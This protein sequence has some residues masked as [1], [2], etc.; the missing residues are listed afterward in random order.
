MPLPHLAANGLEAGDVGLG[1]EFAAHVAAGHEGK[2]LLQLLA[3]LQ[4]LALQAHRVHPRHLLLPVV[5]LGIA[6]QHLEAHAHLVDAV[7][8]RLQLGGLVDDVLGAGDLSAIVQPGAQA[9][10]VALGIGHAHLGKRPLIGIAHALHQRLGQLRH[11]LAVPARVGAL[12][13]D[14][15]GQ[16]ADHGVQQLLLAFN[17]VAR[18]NRH[19][20]RARELLDKGAEVRI[21]LQRI[22]HIPQHQQPQ[23]LPIPRA[24]LHAQHTHGFG[25]VIVFVLV[26]FLC[27]GMVDEVHH[28]QVLRK[29]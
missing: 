25:V 16:Q 28:R 14:G 1:H 8:E 6:P 26:T 15:V 2:V 13:V 12:G 22:G 9:E 20:Q 4:Q 11:A 3:P 5:Q 27:L 7:V 23:G 10:L 17:Q 19:R 29:A 18:F 24:Q 21:V